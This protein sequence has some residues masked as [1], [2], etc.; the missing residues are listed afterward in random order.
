MWSRWTSEK[1][2]LRRERPYQSSSSNR[3]GTAV[4][5]HKR[6]IKSQHRETN[7]SPLPLTRSPRTGTLRTARIPRYAT[8]CVNRTVQNAY[9]HIL[10][11]QIYADATT[12]YSWTLYAFGLWIVIRF[13]G[14]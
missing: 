1:T 2:R 9:V 5:W 7:H 4:V 3:Q 6:S 14:T 11:F 13:F 8:Q 10:I 12:L